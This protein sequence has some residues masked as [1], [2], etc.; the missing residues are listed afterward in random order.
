MGQNVKT[1]NLFLFD[2]KFMYSTIYQVVKHSVNMGV[3][4]N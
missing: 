1:E 2:K 3:V 4:E